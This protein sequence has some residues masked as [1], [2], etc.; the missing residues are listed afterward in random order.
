M[1]QRFSYDLEKSPPAPVLPVRIGVGGARRDATL[2]ALIDTGADVSLIPARVARELRL[3][4]VGQIK[5]RGVTGRTSVDLYGADL[6]VAGSSIRVQ[7]AGLGDEILLG[8]DIVNRWIIVLR[9]PERLLEI[10]S[11][12]SDG[13]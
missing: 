4:V 13:G 1:T 11:V 6:E 7:L 10:E 12:S 2:R 8:R 9:G 5:I 3:P